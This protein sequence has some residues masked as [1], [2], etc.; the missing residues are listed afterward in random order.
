MQS[1]WLSKGYHVSSDEYIL[2]QRVRHWALNALIFEGNWCVDISAPLV[3]H[4]CL[5]RKLNTN[6]VLVT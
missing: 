5:D 2:S 6:V 1:H 4:P 3:V